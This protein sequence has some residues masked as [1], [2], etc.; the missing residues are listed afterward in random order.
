MGAI[1][2]G[3][4]L[5]GG[6]LPYSGTFFIFTDYMRP[7]MR[8]AAMMGLRVIYVLT[9]DSIGLG[10]DGPTHQ[11]IAHLVSLRAIPNMSVIRP[12]DA[13]ETVVAWKMAL[14]RKDG[15]TCLVLTRQNLPIFDRKALGMAAVSDA[16]KGGYVLTEDQNYSAIIIATGS[17]VEIAL[18]AKE[19]LNASGKKVRIVAMPSTDVFDRQSD[20]Y[21]EDVLPHRV[22]NRVAVEAGAT[23]GWYKYVGLEGKVIGIDRF[24]ASAPYETIYKELGITAEAVV[25]TV[26]S[27]DK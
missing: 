4:A 18:E 19:T 10:E 7:S 20:A 21:K 9:H 1:L 26:Q 16:V 2:N 11:P 6:V 27:L 23:L 13:N 25:E 8:L 5:H 22:R 15:P 17:E 24:G 12:M 14:K 3:L